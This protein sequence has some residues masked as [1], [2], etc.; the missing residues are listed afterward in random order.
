MI[1]KK[2]RNISLIILLLMAFVFHGFAQKSFR[3][4]VISSEKVLQNSE[5]GKKA[6]AQLLEKEQKI[7]NE[8]ASI[9]KRVGSLESKLQTQ[10]LILSFEARQQL[11]LDLDRLRTK[12]KRVKEDSTKN[13]QQLQF[14]LFSKIWNEV[15]PIIGTVAKEKEFSLV[16]DI[17][18]RGVVYFDPAFDITNEVIKR[19]NASKATKK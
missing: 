13:Y 15:L 5:E 2:A 6:V 16:L 1:I 18:S 12:R 7:N 4:A 17:T 19:Y 11:A 8:L 3:V 14:R 9:N 10:K